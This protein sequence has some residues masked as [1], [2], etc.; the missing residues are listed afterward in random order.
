MATRVWIFTA[1]LTLTLAA[2]ASAQGQGAAPPQTSRTPAPAA[3]TTAGSPTFEVGLGYQWLRAGDI[4]ITG[5]QECEGSQTYPLGFAIDGVRNFG[6]VG[7]VG[8]FG[9]SRHADDLTDI[10]NQ[11]TASENIFHYAAGVRFTG[12]NAAR[13]W[14][15]GQVLIGAATIRSA[16]RFDDETVDQALGESDTTTKFI[17]QPGVGVTV[18]GGDGWGVFGQVDYRRMFLNED[19]DGASGRNDVRVFVGVRVILD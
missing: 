14:P 4:C 16:V 9:W 13:V 5:N 10:I 18:V 8:E 12:H 15:Y 6:H 1:V 3:S 19:T 2:S 17:I 11:G 7:V